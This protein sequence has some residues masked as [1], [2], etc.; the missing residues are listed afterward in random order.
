MRKKGKSFKKIRKELGVP[1]STLSGW[2]K[3]VP[4]SKKQ[5]ERLKR[6]W[7]N[8]LV[9]ARKKAVVWHNDQKKQRL[10]QAK[11]EARK[12]VSDISLND[13]N[14]LELALAF[15]YLG[16]GSKQNTLA[17][18]N[19]NP[20]ILLFYLSAIELLY[21]AKRASLRYDLHLRADQDPEDLKEYWSRTLS[22]PTKAIRYCAIDK[23]T[24]GK[25]TYKDYKGVCIVTCFDVALQRRLLEI[26]KI[27]SNMAVTSAVSSV[28]R[29]RD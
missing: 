22:I 12:V 19:S 29:A 20:D 4:L 26:S 16:E 21:G 6:D 11:I 1:L 27:Y 2:L 24:M 7:Q 23:R 17:L 15:L 10:E 8:A 9:G 3:C 13:K 25:K 18:G 14:I 28:G 5:R